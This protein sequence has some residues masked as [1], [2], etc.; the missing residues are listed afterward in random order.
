VI[1]R[2]D[3]AILQLGIAAT[4]AGVGIARFAYTPL[5]PQLV[6]QGWFSDSQAVYLGAANLLGYLAGAISAHPLSQ[7]VG[8]PLLLRLSF[9][10]VFLSFALCV[11][12]GWFSWF[13]FW[14]FMAGV[15][16][17]WLMVL[18]PSTALAQAPVERRGS[19]GA[20]VFAG[21]GI[22]AVIASS[23]V[24]LLIH[25]SLSVT[26][27]ALAIACLVMVWLGESGI[28]R[29]NWVPSQTQT[30]VQLDK[31]MMW[32]V[33]LVILAYGLDAIAY[34]PHTLFWVDYL[35]REQQLGMQ[36]ASL[37]WLIFG[38]G[39]CCGPFIAGWSSQRWGIKNALAFAYLAKTS[40]IVLSL[41][42][43]GSALPDFISRSLSS[44]LVGAMIPGVVGLTSAL[45]AEWLG[46]A[47]HKKFWG[48]ATAV[49]A[50]TQALSG[51]GMSA[52]FVE[53]GSYQSLYVIAAMIM[54]A[55]FV[56]VA[57]SELSRGKSHETTT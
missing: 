45:L 56:L 34:V 14:R 15:A 18:A 32:P 11:L 52:L 46:A 25:Q 2:A 19:I 13:F 26:W 50:L 23:V 43:V 24:P 9:A 31:R 41:L 44:F 53:L 47:N 27:A 48:L 16:G 7:R 8:S 21:I 37:Q 17:A 3:L 20:M 28:R 57:C 1:K 36:A 51:Y 55:G 38:I 6:E 49:F 10:A 40:G 5:L 29:L 42:V 33:W 54:A 22:G 39:A 4:L 30:T 12:P 35:A